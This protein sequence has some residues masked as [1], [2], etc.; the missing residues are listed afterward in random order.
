M[1]TSFFHKVLKITQ[2][3]SQSMADI[4]TDSFQ[5][6]LTPDIHELWCKPLPLSVD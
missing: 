3:E 6:S 2:L 4:I 5:L 1:I